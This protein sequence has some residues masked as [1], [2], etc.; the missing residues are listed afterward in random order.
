M[1]KTAFL[2]DKEEILQAIHQYANEKSPDVVKRWARVDIKVSAVPGSMSAE[3]TESEPLP[4]S[5]AP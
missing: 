4:P 1:A 5:P 3:L 2:L